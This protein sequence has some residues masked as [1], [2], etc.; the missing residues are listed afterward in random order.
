MGRGPRLTAVLLLITTG[1]RAAVP[2]TASPCKIGQ[3]SYDGFGHQLESKMSCLAAAVHLGAEYIHV[4]FRGR[5]HGEDV[6]GQ[7][8]FMGF[9]TMFRKLSPP[10]RTV[11]RKP[12]SAPTWPFNKPCRF[13]LARGNLSS[14]CA[15]THYLPSWI[16]KAETNLTFRREACNDHSVFVSDNCYDFL[17]CHPEWPA[18]WLRARSVMHQLYT[19][20]P[21]P[22]PAWTERLSP[23]EESAW[24]GRIVLHARLGDVGER[25]L[26]VGY[27]ARAVETIR[28]EM[29][30]AK[31]GP[32]LFR[33]QTNGL[34]GDVDLLHRHGFGANATDVCS[35]PRPVTRG[36]APLLTTTL[37]AFSGGCGLQPVFDKSAATLKSGARLS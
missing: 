27:Y 13:C 33:V 5:A 25:A 23:S 4:P 8:Q 31:R 3:I 9:A 16:R 36:P 28:T 21:K 20:V 10:M 14:T 35:R 6:K 18:V 24:G 15:Q 22:D 17:N 29:R 34:P 30:E 2:A 37:H 7:E 11:P 19:S 12:S 26:P 1:G 32:P